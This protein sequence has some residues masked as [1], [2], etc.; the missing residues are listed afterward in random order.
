MFCITQRSNNKKKMAYTGFLIFGWTLLLAFVVVVPIVVNQPDGPAP[1]SVPPMGNELAIPAGALALGV[2]DSYTQRVCPQIGAPLAGRATDERTISNAIFSQSEPIPDPRGLNS[3]AWA[4]GQFIDHDIVLSVEDD[5]LI[6]DSIEMLPTEGVFLNL[7]R[8]QRRTGPHGIETLNKLSCSIDG[9]TVYGDYKNPEKLPKLRVNTSGTLQCHMILGPNDTP[10]YEGGTFHCG[11]ERCAEHVL[12]SSLHALFLREHNR[13]CD[14]L[15]ATQEEWTEEQK[16]WKARS[17]TVAVIQHITYSEWLP[18]LFGSQQYLI[19]VVDGVEKGQYTRIA[20]E[21]GAVAYRFGHSMV[22]DKLGEL[23]LRNLFFVPSQTISLG[24]S[25]ILSRALDQHSETADNKVV[26][27]L[28]N[29]L[30]MTNNMTVSED[31]EVRNIYRAREIEMISY[32]DLC[33]CYG[34]TPTNSNTD[35]MVGLLSEPLVEGSSL[36]RTLAVIIAEQFRRL[37]NNDENFYTRNQLSTNELYM[38]TRSKLSDVIIRN[39]ELTQ[40]QVQHNA[41]YK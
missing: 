4:F 17:L 11:D 6:G 16:F 36:P 21:F 34:T 20:T 23:E 5:E 9:S 12:L 28:R 41:F 31:L 18:A 30:F 37:R 7:K 26:D 33:A 25:S 13:W 29:F 10:K 35:P 2:N 22:A 14:H 24:V 39:T 32:Q 8:V 40:E 19:N 3:F 15:D 1:P 38:V 27:G